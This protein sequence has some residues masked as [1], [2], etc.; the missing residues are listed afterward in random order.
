MR[1]WLRLHRYYSR[2]GR[3][4]PRR[5][6]SGRRDSSDRRHRPVLG[7]ALR[8]HGRPRGQPLG[9]HLVTTGHLRRARCPA[10][11]GLS[12]NQRE[13][14][15]ISRPF[16]LPV[17][18]FTDSAPHVESAMRTTPMSGSSASAPEESRPPHWR[19]TKMVCAKWSTAPTAR[20]RLRRPP[21]RV[22]AASWP[23]MSAP[24][25]ILSR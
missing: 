15:S 25:R 8:L 9:D 17:A 11:L 1:A 23:R 16:R 22:S 3:H 21:T 19:H 14:S 13:A 12:Q 4:R 6:R 20:D 5:R 18:P 24:R 2:G 7:R 10:V